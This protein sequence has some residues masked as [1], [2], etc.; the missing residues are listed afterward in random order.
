M[1]SE[2]SGPHPPPAGTCANRNEPVPSGSEL[3][4]PRYG[5]EEPTSGSATSMSQLTRSASDKEP[6]ADLTMVAIDGG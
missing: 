5:S 3:E 2:V 6:L 1:R 4:D